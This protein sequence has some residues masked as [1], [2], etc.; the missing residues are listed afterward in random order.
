MSDDETHGCIN[1]NNFVNLS[2][3]ALSFQAAAF[4]LALVLLPLFLFK[5]QSKELIQFPDRGLVSLKSRRE[6]LRRASEYLLQGA[7]EGYSAFLFCF[8]IFTVIYYY[9]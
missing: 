9:S 4:V 8:H 6:A 5:E 3:L 1:I 7:D 2:Y